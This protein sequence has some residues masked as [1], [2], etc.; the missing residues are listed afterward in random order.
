MT[1]GAIQAANQAKQEQIIHV[2][3][4]YKIGMKSDRNR[5]QKEEGMEN[6]TK[7]DAGAVKNSNCMNV[8]EFM[9]M[10]STQFNQKKNQVKTATREKKKKKFNPVFTTVSAIT[11]Q[12]G[13][14]KNGDELN[15]DKNK[16]EDREIKS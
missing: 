14:Y 2:R 4:N 11:V 3:Q 10:V 1:K 15:I 13:E 6:Q 8:G 5:I 16:G 9:A 12:E 7:R